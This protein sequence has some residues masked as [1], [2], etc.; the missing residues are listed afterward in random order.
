MAMDV[1]C[2]CGASYRLKDEFLGRV[3]KCTSCG[4][5]FQAAAP[6][7]LPRAAQ[8]DPVFDH[9]RFLL[10][11]KA[12]AI[13]QQYTVSDEQGGALCFVVRP[14]HVGRVLLAALG[15]IATL[16]TVIG[17]AIAIGMA[18]GESFLSSDAGAV[19]IIVAI[20]IAIALAIVVGIALSPKRHIMFYRD[21]AKQEK[22]LDVL[23]DSKWQI[24][25]ATYT[26]R[27]AAGNVIAN[28]RKNYL[29]NFFRKR[30]DVLTADRSAMICRAFEDSILLSLLRRWLGPMFGL[31]R[32]NF[33]ITPPE[34]EEIIGEFNRK[35]TLFDRYVLDLARDPARQ[36]DRRVALALGVML[37]TGERR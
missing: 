34:S 19:L 9:D 2:A 4:Q 15:V 36:L 6:P 17:I 33:I 24:I 23:Q 16:V 3:L 31:L 22:L 13:N 5:S 27:D 7:P 21:Q 26:C 30:W 10:R 14:A 25:V 11:Q 18:L 32:T 12:I 1:A 8:A 37:D 35:F 28:F 29:Y 20:V